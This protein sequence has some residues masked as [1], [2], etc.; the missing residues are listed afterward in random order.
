LFE[1]DGKEIFSNRN[2]QT[3]VKTREKMDEKSGKGQS[4]RW[5]AWCRQNNIKC[6]LSEEYSSY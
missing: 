3:N 5:K 4:V 1:T 2:K 6:A